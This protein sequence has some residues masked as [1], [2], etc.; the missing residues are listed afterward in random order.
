M[1]IYLSKKVGIQIFFILLLYFS[2]DFFIV[3]F[4]YHLIGK[5]M[6]PQSCLPT[7]CDLKK[8]RYE[9]FFI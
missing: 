5:Y 6:A 7:A 4:H 9:I 8:C 2:L 1:F 3:I